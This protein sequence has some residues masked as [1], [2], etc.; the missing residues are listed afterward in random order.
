M[1]NGWWFEDKREQ[2]DSRDMIAFG[3]SIGSRYGNAKELA[4][5]LL[6]ARE[7]ALRGVASMISRA[8]YDSKSCTCDIDMT[9]ECPSDSDVGERVIEAAMGTLTQF[10]INGDFYVGNAP[11]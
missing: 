1:S 3:V 5:L 4:E 10:T 8:F 2:V 11:P 7:C 6:F 9:D